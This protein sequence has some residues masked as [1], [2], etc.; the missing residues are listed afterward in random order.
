MTLDEIIDFRVAVA[1]I[2][3]EGSRSN[4][5]VC[6]AFDRLYETAYKAGHG[7]T[8]I[9]KLDHVRLQCER[10][11]REVR[12]PVSIYDSKAVDYLQQTRG[13]DKAK[14]VSPDGYI[15]HQKVPL[16]SYTDCFI[17]EHRITD[18]EAFMGYSP[19]ED[20]PGSRSEAALC[21]SETFGTRCVILNMHEVVTGKRKEISGWYMG[22]RFYSNVRGGLNWEYTEPEAEV[23]QFPAVAEPPLCA[24]PMREAV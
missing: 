23:L 13:V 19:E 9:V 24:E 18:F 8:L 10:P 17:D 4:E 16:P 20:G 2:F 7:T 15:T 5:L 14:I 6:A 1:G 11:D 21:G 3:P 12:V 22:E